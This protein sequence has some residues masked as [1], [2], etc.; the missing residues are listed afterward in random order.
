MKKV[1]LAMMM[2]SSLA[3][4]LH[5]QGNKIPS[6]ETVFY[7]YK[8]Q[9][10]F[11][12]VSYTQMVIGVT[13][14]YSLTELKIAISMQAKIAADSVK[15]TPVKNQ[16]VIK[17]YETAIETQGKSLV[18][19]MA[20]NVKILYIRPCMVGMN[21]KLSSY[22]NDFIVKLKNATSAEQF[23]DFLQQQ[24]CNI[25]RAYMFD[26][27]TFIISAGHAYHYDALKAANV[28]FESGLFEYAEPDISIYNATDAPPNDPLYYLQWNHKNTGSAAQY[29]GTP[30]ADMNVDSAWGITKGKPT[31]KVAVIDEGVDIDHEDLKT[32][33]LQGFDCISLTS[34]IGDGKPRS[35]NNAHG[36]NCA[37][38]IGAI[39]DNNKGIA[40]IAPKCKII[41]VNLADASGYFTSY[42]NIAAGF[43]YAWM[44]GADVIS[45]SWGGGSPSS[46]M[47]DAI[48]RAAT[49]GR[50]GKGCAV[51]FSAGNNNNGLSYPALNSEVMAVG[52]INMCNKRK[53]P[54][55]CDGEY[56]WG[57]SYGTGL[58]IVAPCVKVPSTDITGSAGY[59]SDNYNATFNGTSAACPHAAAVAA[60]I[61]SVDANL[62]GTNARTIIEN[63]ADKIPGYNFQMTTGNING[64]WNNE[65]G[66]GRPDAYHAVLAAQSGSFCNAQITALGPTRFCDGENV[67]LQIV[68]TDNNASYSWYQNNKVISTGSGNVTA[69]KTANY[70]IVATYANGCKATSPGISVSAVKSSDVLTANAGKNISLCNGSPGVR[71]GS[72]P[73]ASGGAA[74][75][76]EKRIYGMDWY[77]NNFYRFSLTNPQDVDT[78]ATNAVSSSDLSSGAFFTGGDF[79]PYGYYGLTRITNRLF[80]ID[81]INGSQKLINTISPSSGNWQG[82]AWDPKDEQLYAMSSYGTQS[83][84]YTVDL[85][86]GNAQFVAT[87]PL[88]SLVWIA[89]DN[90]GKLYALS[91]NNRYIYQID[92]TTGAATALPNI[93]DAGLNYAQDADF[94]PVSGVLHLTAFSARQNYTGDLRIANTATGTVSSVGTISQTPYNEIDATG[95]AGYTY[96]YNWSP[97]TGLSNT[98]DANPFAN[99]ASNTTYTLTVTDLCGNQAT[100]KIKVTV[101]ASKPK[102]KIT[103]E[104]SSICGLS[105]VRL[106]ATADDDYVYQ[107]YL[108]G[109][110]ISGATDSFY[111]AKSAGDYTVQVSAGVGGCQNTSKIFKLK[112]CADAGL[113]ARNAGENN[114]TEPS[115][116]Y[117]N[118]ANNMIHIT[119]PQS[120]QPS[121]VTIYDM[122][123]RI[124]MTKH[125]E[126]NASKE[127]MDISKLAKG[128]YRVLWTQDKQIQ[129]LKFVKQ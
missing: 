13:E 127:K 44:N 53:D 99:P 42:S 21:G 73:S 123:G 46:L 2:L 114:I 12:N 68:N 108:G 23:Q 20:G 105:K 106:S 116:L 103:A 113:A 6:N 128:T 89:F 67:K 39:A 8:G 29:Y 79:T 120:N 84:L 71:I 80:R 88:Y 32:N 110:K 86:T 102:A 59:S 49:Q 28:F 61:F 40:G 60:L 129:N 18:A 118:P 35:T 47:D 26:K 100:A 10:L 57:A 62:T 83:Q 74:F 45:N 56:W 3:T 65:M 96:Q 27:G 98:K 91:L 66:Y 11:F 125:F 82:L 25:V 122:Q 55:S 112:D 7:Y 70:Y 124:V 1:L 76:N 51:F 31:I 126:K 58:S 69:K 48:H 22:G 117:P 77:S 115:S 5:A 95:I 97:A 93:T 101:G 14:G 37:G 72:M 64:T 107:W 85:I 94:D 50:S 87:I 38:I 30:G 33:M 15:Q 36:T 92:K 9:K 43:D 104:T 75:L 63:T 41:P 54:A 19:N 90:K 81:T 17:L 16:F 24:K 78:V 34:N 109:A 111:V 121:V 119:L 52:G 4:A